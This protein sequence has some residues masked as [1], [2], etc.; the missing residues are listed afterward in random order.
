MIVNP[1]IQGMLR[2]LVDNKIY[3]VVNSGA[4]V[5]GTSGTGVN[6]AGPGSTLTDSLTGN[7][8]MQVGTLA[9]PVWVL[10]GGFSSAQQLSGTITAAQIISV[11]AGNFGH[12]N[13]V[14]LVPAS[15][16]HVVNELVSVMMY[17]DFSVAAY[18]AG[19]NIT[20]NLGAAG[21]PLTGLVS[22][23]NSVGAAAD[24]VTQF[25]VLTTAG[26]VL[27]ENTSLN[28]VTSA[29]FTNPGTAAGVIRWVAN[30]RQYNTGF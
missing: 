17:Y 7:K 19:G 25:N 16:A 2:D 14:I 11:A 13:G 6:L 12:A 21:S 18:T 20:V 10:T 4:P 9:S 24:K 23:A 26:I 15:G 1:S 3:D 22:A 30:F 27:T 5:N 28:L 8:Y 29:A